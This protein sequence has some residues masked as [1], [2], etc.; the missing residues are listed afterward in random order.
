VATN[1]SGAKTF[2]YG[3]SRDYVLEASIILPDGETLTLERGKVF[4]DGNKLNLTTDSG[5]QISIELPDYQMPKTKHAAGYF[6]KENMDALDL[7]I[8]S[9]GTLGIFSELKLKL[10][11]LSE[12]ILSAVMFFDQED[13]ALNFVAEARD[14]SVHSRGNG[15]DNEI[16][17]RGL[18]FFDFNSLQFLKRDYPNIP[19]NVEGAVWF[20]QETNSENEDEILTKWVELIYK[21]N[22]DEEKAWMALDKKERQKF[23]DFRHAVSWK[24]NEYITQKNILKVGTDIAVPDNEFFELYQNSKKTVESKEIDYIAYGHFG[25]SHLHLNMLPKDPEEYKT[26]KKIYAELCEKAVKLGGTIS[27]EHGIGKLKRNYL[28]KMFGEERIQQM[29]AIKRQLDP[30]K[31]LGIGNIFDPKYL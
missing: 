5:K 18:E 14:L 6:V 20:E 3:P 22:G 13:D 11:P 23:Q 8:G 26:A 12:N 10:L 7:F 15:N 27:A 25:N 16:N 19:E 28:L 30:N 2:K 21:H 4:A 24:V 17:A 1:S 29:A 9:E 31:I